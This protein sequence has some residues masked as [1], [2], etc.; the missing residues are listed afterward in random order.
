MQR[1]TP[2]RFSVSERASFFT[3]RL[4]GTANDEDLNK[5]NKIYFRSVGEVFSCCYD[6][7]YLN[8][9]LVRS[10]HAKNA[11]RDLYIVFILFMVCT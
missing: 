7:A 10:S 11:K 3:I 2:F 9:L 8:A 5:N 4:N 6:F 1:A